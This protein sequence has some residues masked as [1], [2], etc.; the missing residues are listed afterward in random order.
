MTING[1]VKPIASGQTLNP[2]AST[3]HAKSAQSCTITTYM[4]GKGRWS[5]DIFH[6]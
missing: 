4:A 3:V 2:Q 1:F 5:I 6:F